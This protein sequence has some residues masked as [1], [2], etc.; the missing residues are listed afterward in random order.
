MRFIIVII[1]IIGAIW[2]FS[3]DENNSGSYSDPKGSFLQKQDCS[4]LEP[5]NP[6]SAGSG[7][8]AGFEWGE[9]GNSC[10]G[11]ST[12]FIDGCEEYLRQEDAYNSCVS[13]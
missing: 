2:F 12:S 10:G 3:G 8:Y 5:E 11:N 7:H 9:N 1:L 13:R 4:T 6:Y